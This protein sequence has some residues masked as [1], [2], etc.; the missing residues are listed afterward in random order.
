[1]GKLRINE[2]NVIVD[3]I[4]KKVYEKNNKKIEN[5]IQSYKPTKQEKQYLLLLEQINTLT[6]KKEKLRKQLQ[7]STSIVGGFMRDR[8]ISKI[9]PTYVNKTILKNDI[10]LRNID[11]LFNVETFIN[12]IVNSIIPD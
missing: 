3:T 8:A 1:M 9:K 2:I 5:F 7:V 11:P 6:E 10:I 4:A 12:D